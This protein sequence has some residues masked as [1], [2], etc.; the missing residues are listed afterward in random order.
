[1]LCDLVSRKNKKLTI[2]QI[3]EKVF[4]QMTYLV[5]SFMNFMANAYVMVKSME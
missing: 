5:R 1:M 2:L 4:S 3:F